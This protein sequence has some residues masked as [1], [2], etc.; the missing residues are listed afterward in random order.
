MQIRRLTSDDAVVYRALRL[1]GLRE[2][3][4]AF[5]SSWED[6]ERKPLAASQSR[7]Q[8]PLSTF[9]GAFEATRSWASWGWNG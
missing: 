5:T 2:H 3:P 8:D 1:R 4:E 7:L 6:D 9:W